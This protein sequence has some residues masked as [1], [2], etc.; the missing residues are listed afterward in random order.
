MKV[1]PVMSAIWSMNSRMSASLRLMV[2]A[3]CWCCALPGAVVGWAA[4]R[5]RGAASIPVAI[6]ASVRRERVGVIVSFAFLGRFGGRFG[7]GVFRVFHLLAQF[8]HA[9][10]QFGGV[11]FLQASEF[12]D[13]RGGRF[14]RAGTDGGEA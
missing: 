1:S 14:V 8:L 3:S 12:V 2:Q 5:G 13:H 10:A 4:Y 6:R 9:L 7:G 11:V